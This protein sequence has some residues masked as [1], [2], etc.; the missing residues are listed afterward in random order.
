[1]VGGGGELE[2]L[3]ESPIYECTSS[4]I[5]ILVCSGSSSD[6][7]SNRECRSDEEFIKESATN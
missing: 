3:L 6:P 2:N 7:L 1:M 4:K 5:R